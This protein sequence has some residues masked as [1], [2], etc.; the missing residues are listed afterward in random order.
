MADLISQT[1]N[2]EE[3]RSL[4]QA[5][6]GA[7]LCLRYPLAS[8][9]LARDEAVEFLGSKSCG[10]FRIHNCVFIVELDLPSEKHF[11][12]IQEILKQQKMEIW[13]LTREDRV[14]SW[15]NE[16][17]NLFGRRAHIVVTS[18]ESFVG[19][20]ITE[21]AGFSSSA[22]IERIAELVDIYNHRWVDIVGSPSIRISIE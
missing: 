11:G 10:D 21:L 6:V 4:A 5:L 3:E 7:T 19:Q 12:R 15:K 22:K 14:A 18:V 2:T 17:S 16:V 8:R 1:R 20:N 9:S 13:L